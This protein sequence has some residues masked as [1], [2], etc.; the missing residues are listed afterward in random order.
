MLFLFAQN[1]SAQIF[2]V[3]LSKKNLAKIE[4]GKT[5]FDKLKRYRKAY[6]HDSLKKIKKIS[7]LYHKKMDSLAR[8]SAKEEK[9]IATFILSGVS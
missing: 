7:K 6:S 8:V 1:L 2:K 5:A 3:D 9:L 4:K